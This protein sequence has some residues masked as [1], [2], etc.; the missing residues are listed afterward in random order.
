MINKKILIVTS[1]PIVY[2]Q[3]GGQKRAK[4]IY[5]LYAKIFRSVKIVG[6]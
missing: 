6:V 5:G 1:Y 2:P 4:A 3:H